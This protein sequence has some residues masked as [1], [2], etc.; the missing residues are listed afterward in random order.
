MDMIPR[1]SSTALE[2]AA[3]L[4]GF[5]AHPPLGFDAS[6]LPSGLPSFR[7]PLDLTTT[8]DD[9]LRSRLLG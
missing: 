2:P 1:V 5:L 3:L 6:R 7:A 4:E 8:L 9:A